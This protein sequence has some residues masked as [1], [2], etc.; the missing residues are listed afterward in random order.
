MTCEHDT[1]GIRIQETVI[2]V[3]KPHC[4]G[5][6][7]TTLWDAGNFPAKTRHKH[8]STHLAS[9]YSN[10]ILYQNISQ[11]VH[12]QPIIAS[13]HARRK[14]QLMKRDFIKKKTKFN[15]KLVGM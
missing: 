12:F 5:S 15:H 9:V 10:L 4:V 6:H 2:R 7:L 14:I 1:K 8:C 13:R 3:W 11:D